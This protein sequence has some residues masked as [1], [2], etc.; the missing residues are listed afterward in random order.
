M[1]NYLSAQYADDGARR[2]QALL[3]LAA[4]AA[5]ETHADYSPIE[6]W[7]IAGRLSEAVRE[8]LRDAAEHPVSAQARAGV[9]EIIDKCLR[10]R[11]AAE[12]QQYPLFAEPAPW[13]RAPVV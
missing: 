4:A 12:P 13:T 3:R 7:A 1:T 8:W 5:L 9:R 6:A 2:H 10:R 11:R